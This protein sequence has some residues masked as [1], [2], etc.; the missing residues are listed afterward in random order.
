[1]AN[2]HPALP[3]HHVKVLKHIDELDRQ[4]SLKAQSGEVVD[5]TTLLLWFTFDMMG[6][7]TFSKSF[8]MLKNQE[9]HHI[10]LKM[11]N[12][13]ALLG[14]LAPTPWLLHLG[15]KLLP[16]RWW[17]KDWYDSVTW[18][19]AQMEERLSVRAKPDVPDLTTYLLEKGEPDQMEAWLRGDSLLAILAG[20]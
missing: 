3:Y 9:F 13:R 7:F 20:R 6:D 2:S 8:E 10:I 11:Q 4:L 16:K 1:M 15:L 12:A 18:S 19:H 17:V 14:P 5:A